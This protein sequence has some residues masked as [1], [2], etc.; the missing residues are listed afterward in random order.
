MLT[1][2]GLKAITR[3]SFAGYHDPRFMGWGNLRVIN[4]DRVAPGQGLGNTV[5]AIWKSSAMFCQGN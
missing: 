2:V 3:F 1:T 4:E 5:T